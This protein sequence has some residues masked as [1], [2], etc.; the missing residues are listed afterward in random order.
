MARTQR[1]LQGHACLELEEV[2]PDRQQIMVSR[3]FGTWV[4]DPQD[5]SEALATFAMRATEKLRARGLTTCAIGIFA[6][7]DW[8]SADIRVKMTR[9]I[10][11]IFENM[12]LSDK[13]ALPSAHPLPRPF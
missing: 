9:R 4:T 13:T 3:S 6:E 10:G 8:G 11:F 7:T 12:K 1:E 2:E 5:M